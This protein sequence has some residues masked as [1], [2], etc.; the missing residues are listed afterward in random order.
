MLFAPKKG[1]DLRRELSDSVKES[2]SEG[3]RTLA[4]AFQG[5][6]H[7]MAKEVKAITNSREMQEFVHYGEER[8]YDILALARN[9]GGDFAATAKEKL[10]QLS[11]FAAKKAQ[12]LGEMSK[13][14]AKEVQG[15]MSDKV[16][17]TVKDAGKSLKSHKT[18]AVKKIKKIQKKVMGD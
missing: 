16:Q 8:M 14:Q 15:K 10:E 11:E 2:H 5:A 1:K 4:K 13:E 7:E 3:F 6:G 17:H 12:E 18:K 9:R